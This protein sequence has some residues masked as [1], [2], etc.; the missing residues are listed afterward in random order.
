MQFDEQTL[1]LRA[2]FRTICVHAGVE[3]WLLR[4][5]AELYTSS[6]TISEISFGIERLPASRRRERLQRD[7]LEIVERMG[8]RILRFDTRTA[9]MWGKRRASTVRSGT[10]LPIVDSHIAAIALRHGLTV[11]TRNTQDF[12][13]AGIKTANPFE[14]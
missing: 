4:H 9:L 6:F 12:D 1:R 3:S 14:E 11:A 2:S 8:D 10:L 5:E 7:L 13:R